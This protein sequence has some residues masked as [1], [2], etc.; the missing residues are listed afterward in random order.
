VVISPGLLIWWSSHRDYWSG[1]H[2]T[3]VIHKTSFLLLF[4]IKYFAWRKVPCHQLLYQKTT[5][6]FD[7]VMDRMSDL[8]WR[9]CRYDFLPSIVVAKGSWWS[10]HLGYWSGSHLTWVTDLV[11]ITPGLLIWWSSHLGYWS[12]GHLT[13]VIHKTSFLLLFWIKYFAW[14]NVPRHQLLYQKTTSNFDGVMDR[15]SDL[16]WR[17]CRYDFLPSI[18]VAKGSWGGNQWLSRK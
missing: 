18:V 8:W 4:W 7:G 2:L 6:N 9:G 3:L 11:V 17:G 5:S 10:S 14:R 12:G 15:M 13:W 1:G 16:W